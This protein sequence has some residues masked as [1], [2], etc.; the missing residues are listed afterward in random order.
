MSTVSTDV[1]RRDKF[2]QYARGGV[3]YYW[4]VDPV[5]R[6]IEAYRLS[7]GRYRLVASGA[8]DQTV[9]LPP[10]PDLEIPLRELWYPKRQQ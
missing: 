6:T 5:A 7:G 1:D 2:K 4:I 8:S 3:A 10:V 9:R